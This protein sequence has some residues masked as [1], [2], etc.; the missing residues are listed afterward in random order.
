MKSPR[1]ATIA[2]DR[3]GGYVNQIQIAVTNMSERVYA[4]KGKR[5]LY[6]DSFRHKVRCITSNVGV[7]VAKLKITYEC[8]YAK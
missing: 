1:Q 2:T 6:K 3:G 4:S 5:Q 8:E 7:I